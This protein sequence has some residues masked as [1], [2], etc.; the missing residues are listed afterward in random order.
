MVIFCEECGEKYIIE[1]NEVTGAAMIF[2]CRTCGDMIRV[3][4]PGSASKIHAHAG[5]RAESS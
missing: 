3:P 4:I 1:P 5:E 2:K